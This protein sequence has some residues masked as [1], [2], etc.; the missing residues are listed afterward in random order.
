MRLAPDQLADALRQSLLPIYLVAGEEAQLVDECLDQLR[1][2]ARE[3]GFVERQVLDVER[4]FDWSL[5][6]GAMQAMSLFASRKLVEVR[7]PGGA[8]GKEGGRLLTELAQAPS[9]DVL[10][11]VICGE[12]DY[13]QQ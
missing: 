10:L 11:L 13:R 2:A 5:L 7:M 3:Q 8:P 12:L 6:S 9:P 4:G 1:Q